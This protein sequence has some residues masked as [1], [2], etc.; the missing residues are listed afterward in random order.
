MNFFLTLKNFISYPTSHVIVA[1]VSRDKKQKNNNKIV[2]QSYGMNEI[3]LFISNIQLRIWSHVQAS[4]NRLFL[5][6]S[7]V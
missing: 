6:I 5:H 3:S 4:K 7:K 2:S 1:L